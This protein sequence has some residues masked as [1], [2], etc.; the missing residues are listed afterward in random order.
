VVAGF[1]LTLQDRKVYNKKESF[2]V[3]IFQKLNR[4]RNM[5][6]TGNEVKPTL[7]QTNKYPMW[8]ATDTNWF[9]FKKS[10]QNINEQ[11]GINFTLLTCMAGAH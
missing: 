4:W 7:V 6:L 5:C 2:C 1:H 3:N 11:T 9:C 10:A 8:I